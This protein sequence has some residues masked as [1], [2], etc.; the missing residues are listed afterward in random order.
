MYIEKVNVCNFRN[1]K[2]ENVSLIN[3]TNVFFGDNAQGK[4][5]F[6]ESVF[7]ASMGKSFKS[8]KEKD[9]ILFGEK[10]AAISVSYHKNGRIN[11]NKIF[12]GEKK[13]LFINK[14]PVPKRIDFIGKLNTVLFTPQELS[15]I[16]EGPYYRRKFMDLCISQMRIKYMHTLSSYNKAL[17]QKNRLLKEN[18]TETLDIWNEKL[19]QYGSLILWYRNSFIKRIK[20]VIDDIYRQIAGKN[21]CLKAAYISSVK[22]EENDSAEKISQRFME[23][24]YINKENEINGQCAVI[25]PHRD[26]ILFYINGKNTRNFASQGQQRSVVLALKIMQTQL[27]FEETGEYPVLLLDD[28]ASELDESRRNFL[29]DRIKDKQVII[30]CTD[31]EKLKFYENSH[32]YNVC[33]GK[34]N[35]VIQKGM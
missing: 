2:E 34:I 19:A 32:Y 13:K 7:L 17:E 10:N 6:I 8:I 26:D 4:T 21:E 33:G 23:E 5:N 9:L 25:G 1:F 30:T 24:L 16:R 28:I 31:A 35:E 27:F 3:G 14:V 12:L 22:V 20:P 15:I 29:F 11:E 18:K